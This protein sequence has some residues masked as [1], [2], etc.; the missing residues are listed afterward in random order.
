[1]RADLPP[2]THEALA[3]SER[4]A[5]LIAGEIAQAGGWIGF[6]RYMELA[7]YAPGLGYYAAGAT[8]LGGAGDFVTAPELS[9][10]FSRTLARQAAE[11]LA[12]I[13]GEVLE[14]GPGSG[15][16]AA[17]LLMA[18][19]ELGRLPDRYLMLEVSAD[20]R[21]RQERTLV[22]L[23][24]A[25]RDRVRW[26]DR[27]PERLAGVVLANEV[28]DALPVEL[29]IWRAGE[30]QQRGVTV[31]GGRF[32][33]EDRPLP[34]GRLREEAGRLARAHAGV[35][36]AAEYVSELGLAARELTATLGRMLVR[37]ALVFVDYGFGEAELYHPQRD[38][39]T[40]MCHYRHRAHD[41]PFVWP[42][43]Q[44]ITAHV[45]F[46]AVAHAGVGAGLAL[47]GYASQA[48]FLVN[49]GITDVLAELPSD[50]AAAYAR[51]V[52]PVQKLLS[53]AEMGELFK[54]LALGRGLEAPL[55]GFAR[56][57]LTRLL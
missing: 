8:K 45:D 25:L 18:L 51:A 29:V 11:I 44:D 50:D 1:L 30:A 20:L 27:L 6:A 56:G 12:R 9:G 2:P 4:L 10:L 38:R 22:A 52:A 7:L 37:G 33:H 17:D 28:L 21:E 31:R 32:E 15:R 24:R 53:P 47:L 48:N 35:G 55:T 23:P 54:V 16:M 13:G 46:S 14:L 49:L 26:I 19:A 3:H 39:G 5:E 36:G 41:D 43:L 40:L 42:G 57:D 34:A